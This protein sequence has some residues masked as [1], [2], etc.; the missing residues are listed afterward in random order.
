[1]YAMLR[2]HQHFINGWP[3]FTRALLG[4]LPCG[5]IAQASKRATLYSLHW[6]PAAGFNE[7]I[8]A[9]PWEQLKLRAERIGPGNVT[10]RDFYITSGISVASRT[11]D[12]LCEFE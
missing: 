6:P 3:A 2:L 8:F 5:F 10:Q 1:M 9:E 7:R 4:L 11:A 12:S